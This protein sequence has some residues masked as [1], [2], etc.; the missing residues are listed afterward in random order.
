MLSLATVTPRLLEG[1]IGRRVSSSSSSLN[2]SIP[3]SIVT[4]SDSTVYVVSNDDYHHPLLYV[5]LKMSSSGI[6]SFIWN[7]LS[8]IYILVGEVR[9]CHDERIGNWTSPTHNTV[10]MAHQHQPLYPFLLPCVWPLLQDKGRGVDHMGDHR[11]FRLSTRTEACKEWHWVSY[12]SWFSK[13][14]SGLRRLIRFFLY[15]W[16][17]P[18]KKFPR[19]PS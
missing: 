19:F 14:P 13:I 7:I 11:C 3:S 18:D 2:R 9:F 12:F 1:R 4:D 6:S 10:I 8:V 5:L 15:S 17:K 16:S